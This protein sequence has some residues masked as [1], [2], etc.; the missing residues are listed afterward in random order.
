MPPSSKV[1]VTIFTPEPSGEDE[2]GPHPV[3]RNELDFRNSMQLPCAHLADAPSPP[4]PSPS[5]PHSPFPS[6][7][8]HVNLLLQE[9]SAGGCGELQKRGKLVL[10]YLDSGWF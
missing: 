5:P 8:P 7:F 6:P 10:L 4:P 1:E 3:S 9:G 2:L